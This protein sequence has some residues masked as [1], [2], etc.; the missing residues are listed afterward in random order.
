MSDKKLNDTLARLKALGSDKVRLQNKKAG[1][2]D[3]QFGVT[4]GDIRKIADALKSDHALALALWETGN[5][6]A[7]QLAC[8]I[9]KPKL[10]SAKELER[11]AKSLDFTW[12]ADWL[13][14]YVIKNH[15]EKDTLRQKWMSA[16]DRWLARFGWSLTA[17][18]VTK[19][20]EGLDVSALLDR[21]EAEMEN[22]VPEVQ[23]T[24][25]NTLAA[26]GINVPKLR[27]RA[28]SIGEKLGVYRDYPVSKGCTSPFAPIWI[29]EMVKRQG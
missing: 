19:D 26:I 25:N 22:A 13:S 16:K 9:V 27:K 14:S 7:R 15:P 6:E 10:L 24:M 18:R 2:G 3:N 28:L 17:E 1:A 4:R 29:N 8:L 5:I 21:I 20:P 23:W 12:T 11:M